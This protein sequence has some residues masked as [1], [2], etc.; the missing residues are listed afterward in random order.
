MG[1]AEDAFADEEGLH[2][3]G[4]QVEGGRL[5]LGPVRELARA[6][7]VVH[8]QAAIITGGG[9]GRWGRGGMPGFGGLDQPV[10]LPHVQGLAP[11]PQR[12]VRVVVLVQECCA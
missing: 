10:P 2:A 12:L 8:A 5:Q 3:G 1:G 11:V 7:V 6:A 4:V 9:G